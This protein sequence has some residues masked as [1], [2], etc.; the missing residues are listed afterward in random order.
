[1]P[2]ITLE[3]PER[4][5]VL[6]SFAGHLESPPDE[7]FARLVEHLT[8][9][10]ARS[11]TE[12]GLLVD[13]PTRAVIVQGEWWYRGEYAVLPEGHG[14]SVVEYEIVNVA[15]RAHRAAPF[16]GRR[17]IASAPSVFQALLTAI[18]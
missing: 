15:Q 17:E 5:T 18:G 8:A 2:A 1:M 10:A 12:S 3:R 11:G 16:A 7:V 13:E 9:E 14:D 6:R 4:H